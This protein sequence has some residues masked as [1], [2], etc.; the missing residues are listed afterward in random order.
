MGS[1]AWSQSAAQHIRAT[2][3]TKST[4]QIFTQN[5]SKKIAKEM[6]PF[7]LTIRE[8][9]DSATHPESYPVAVF[10]DVT[11][12]MGRIPEELVRNSLPTLMD[13][14]IEHGTEHP[15]VMFSAI[16]DQFD[17]APLQIGQFEAGAEEVNK[18]LGMIWLE[19]NGHGDVHEAYSL[20]WLCAGRHMSIDSFEK[21]GQKGI[22][23][24]VGD[25]APHKIINGSRIKEIMG[26]SEAS[27]LSAE[28]ILEEAKRLFHIFHIHVEQGSYPSTGGGYSIVS[29]WR[30]LL[31]ERV[32]LLD[33]YTQIAEVIG[34]TVALVHGADIQ[35]V[36]ST[37]NDS[38]AKGVSKALATIDI[39]ALNKNQEEGVLIL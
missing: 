10:L 28:E 26:Y 39:T 23:F 33:D 4:N 35:K 30:E 11:G 2:T 3:S 27:D 14:I 15:H 25:E 21:R 18:D 29:A 20:A 34:T 1:S 32:I 6:N 9:R 38:T 36:L 22:L 37:F 5:V 24:T 16:G 19:G 7:G 17:D 8:S 12:S 31:P 13:V